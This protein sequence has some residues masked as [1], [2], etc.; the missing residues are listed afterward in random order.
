[1]NNEKGFCKSI[2]LSMLALTFR[3]VMKSKQKL[4]LMV[5]NTKY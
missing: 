5:K 1:M 2:K 4:V 3:E